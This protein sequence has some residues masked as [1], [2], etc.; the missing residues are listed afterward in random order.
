MANTMTFAEFQMHTFG[1][2]CI[3]TFWDDFTIAEKYGIDAI[4]DTYKRSF[5][6]FKNE[7]KY[8]TELAMVLDFKRWT[9][10]QNNNEKLTD[11][12]SDLYF[13]ILIWVGDNLTGTAFEYWHSIMD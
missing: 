9:H 8:I 7:Y 1:Y 13:K 5:D 11:V 12:Y 2:E 6:D 10:S 4:K 3:T